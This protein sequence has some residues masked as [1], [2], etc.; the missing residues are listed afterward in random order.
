MRI[1]GRRMTLHALLGVFSVLSCSVL[2]LVT[3]VSPARGVEGHFL[4]SSFATFG[5]PENIAVDETTGDLYV[6]DYANESI[7]R[8]DAS[9]NPVEFAAVGSNVLDGV[10]G[11]DATPEGAF[12]FI[13][14]GG[15]EVAIDNSTGANKGDIYVANM[16]NDTV[17]IFSF[18]GTYLGELTSGSG[19]HWGFAC[20]VAVDKAGSVYVS[21]FEHAINKFVPAGSPATNSD[22][23]SAVQEGVGH[24]CTI[25]V[26]GE[27]SVY[28]ASVFGGPVKKWTASQFGSA[29]PSS[30][31][32]AAGGQGIA[33][34][35]TNNRVFV[36]LGTH[37]VEY[38]PLGNQVGS[39]GEGVFSSSFGLGVSGTTGKVY[40]ADDERQE[41]EIFTGI[42]TMP[43][44]SV[45]TP[46]NLTET[47]VTLNAS[48][49][50]DGLDA[51][52]KVQYGLDTSYGSEVPCSP[53]DLG[54]GNQGIATSAALSGLTLKTIYH[55]RF[56]TSNPNG[57]EYGAD[58]SFASGSKPSVDGV[59]MLDVSTVGATIQ[60]QVNPNNIPTTFQ[61]EYGLSVSYGSS[62]PTPASNVGSGGSDQTVTWTLGGLQPATTYHYR[63][64]A[65]DV[66]GT[67]YGSDQTFATFAA[68]TSG[69][70]C[71]NAA[72]REAQGASYLPDCRAYELVSPVEKGSANI[73]TEPTRDQASVDGNAVKYWSAVAFGSVLG[74]EIP[75]AEYIGRRG[76]AGWSTQSIDPP[77]K[78]PSGQGMTPEYAYM[79]PDLSK[80]IFYAL[81]PIGAG[82]PNVAKTPNLYLRNDIFAEGAGDYELL[83]DSIT[84]LPYIEPGVKN[85]G[86]ALAGVSADLTHV[87]FESSGDLTA[88]TSGL[89]TGLPK[90]YEWD[91]GTLRLVGILPDG[92][93]AS[94][95]VVGAGAG[96][97]DELFNE[98]Y[99]DQTAISSDGSRVVFAGPPLVN[100]GSAN[101]VRGNLYMRIDG[102]RTIQLNVSERSQPDPNPFRPAEFWGASADGSRVFFISSQLLTN[103]ASGESHLP[104][105][106]NASNLY[107]YDLNA[108]EGKRV[109]LISK[110]EEPRGAANDDCG[111]GED[112]ATAVV[113]VSE[114]GSYVY[115][116]GRK[117]LVPGQPEVQSE[118]LYVWHDGT[119]RAVAERI[120]SVDPDWGQ[121]NPEWHP[122][123]S[124]MLRVTPDGRHAV[125][126][127]PLSSVAE[128]AGSQNAGRTE[129]C[130]GSGSQPAGFCREVYVYDY[131][132]DRLT[133]ASCRPAG[134]PPEGEASFSVLADN[135]PL[136]HLTTYLSHPISSDG[137]YVFFESMDPLVPQASNGRWNVYEYDTT[138]A[139]VHLISGG[140]CDC[141]SHFI[142]ASADGRNVFFTT[143]QRLVH[144]DV[145]VS[146]DLYD[147]RVEGGL[148]SQNVVEAPPCTG[149]SCQ[150][151][152]EGAPSFSLP[153]SATFA[154]VG[155]VAAPASKAKPKK[156]KPKKAKA[157]KTAAK[158]KKRKVK[159]KTHGGAGRGKRAAQSGKR[160]RQASRSARRASRRAGR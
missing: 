9:G 90:A 156:T 113:G 152:A 40:V 120:A 73:A 67:V 101:H 18:N 78:A 136:D 79:S 93:P 104:N 121:V 111:C 15:G 159:S 72:P 83:S 14:E 12:S 116:L 68:T 124:N 44:I 85:R 50:P 63:V 8:F 53:A 46:S 127:S 54:A 36:D 5:N 26:D 129:A 2:L 154:G 58:H 134:A 34:D 22:F 106:T 92:E 150:T 117:A 148:A 19:A 45:G 87:A 98:Q 11:A 33:V 119:L 97:G 158:S 143:A 65:S 86:V 77:Q 160:H 38:D 123:T 29:A 61:V 109:T 96:G 94:G 110:D 138:T 147:A 133:C 24:L 102:T 47:S 108:P 91:R 64:A 132:T 71:P 21:S 10:S 146:V 60:A 57:L 13:P 1:H 128:A 16:F 144:S 137:R 48:I 130:P 6:L 28:G 59:A 95:S 139:Q 42:V 62:E 23:N 30:T 135:G 89:S 41:V 155:N 35:Q 112:R 55:Y 37:V 4:L 32:L 56:V 100:G 103:D 126:V 153:A 141:N 74:T 114:D 20:G 51:T 66:F 69:G 105:G 118:D 17:D 149:D 142:D 84:P 27:G 75:G 82:N 140:T 81:T 122:G 115:F 131:G 88:E 70:S 76:P 39:F 99:I 125:F 151:A 107:M 25:A 43:D 80:G 52:C 3:T 157:K 145:D 7:Q 49:D 31:V